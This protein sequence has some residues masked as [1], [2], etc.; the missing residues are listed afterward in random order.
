MYCD[1]A[2]TYPG[3]LVFLKMVLYMA[4]LIK[5]I[6][7]VMQYWLSG[8][9]SSFFFISCLTQLSKIARFKNRHAREKHSQHAKKKRKKEKKKR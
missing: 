6:T 5:V 9:A 7:Y 8:Y 2:L 3:I 4:K 1:K